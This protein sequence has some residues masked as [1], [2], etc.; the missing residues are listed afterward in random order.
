MERPE[1]AIWAPSAWSDSVPLEKESNQGIFK[2]M[3]IVIKDLTNLLKKKPVNETVVADAA[4]GLGD[5]LVE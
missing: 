2:T 5:C 4:A 3:N 1:L